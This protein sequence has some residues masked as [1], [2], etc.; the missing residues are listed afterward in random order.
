ME[1]TI[2]FVLPWLPYPLTTGGHQAIFNGLMAARDVA[3]I[4]ITYR[5]YE[6]CGNYK[7]ELS[8]IMG[9][10]VQILPYKEASEQVVRSTTIMHRAYNF[11]ASCKHRINHVIKRGLGIEERGTASTPVPAYRE[12]IRELYPTDLSFAKHVNAIIERHNVTIVQCEMIRNLSIAYSLPQNVKKIFVH[13]ELRT[14]VRTQELYDMQ[15]DDLEK[16]AYLNFYAAN[17]V[18]LL[19]YFDCVV[20]LSKIDADKLRD[21]GVS[22]QVYPSFAVVTNQHIIPSG[23][24]RRHVLSFVGSGGHS[25]NK[26]GLI[27]FLENCWD[28][29]LGYDGEYR[30]QVIGEWPAEDRLSLMEHYSNVD[31][32]GF[33]EDLFS[34]LDGT[35]MIVPIIRGSGIRMKILEAAKMGV[36]VV[37]TTIGAEGLPLENGTHCLI[38]DDPEHFVASIQNYD[39]ESLRIRV[40]DNA[41]LA[42]KERYSFEA[43]RKNRQELYKYINCC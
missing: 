2:L 42:M 23:K 19:N 26:H 27:W 34:A 41:S 6:D 40:V 28:T 4:V 29:L 14:V 35:I 1:T 43:F 9:G 11:Y 7:E 13:H 21:M 20:T 16:K 31:F 17:E 30:L 33:V 5:E 25:P 32:L 39:E 10:N 24:V 8:S 22:T 37:T 18:A 38:A 15:G 3:N 36:P 12:W